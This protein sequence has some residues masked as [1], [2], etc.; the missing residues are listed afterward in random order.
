ME[1]SP[2]RHAFIAE[3]GGTIS[4][5]R[6]LIFGA[7][8]YNF[9]QAKISMSGEP[10]SLPV[11]MKAGL[12]YLPHKSIMVCIETVKYVVYPAAFKAGLEY[13]PVEKLKVRTGISS[14]PHL[15][16]FGIGFSHRRFQ[17]D[18][19]TFFHHA[20]GMSNQIAVSYSFL[21]K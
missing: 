9:N 21:R 20:L 8:L 18:Y 19:A 2:T 5:T 14:A 4:L 13:A 11:I 12:T 1:D 3:L 7:H 15:Y 17:A 6:S 10:V 16:S